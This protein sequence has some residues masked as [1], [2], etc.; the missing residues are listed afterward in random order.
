MIGGVVQG[1]LTK[2][3]LITFQCMSR[4]VPVVKISALRM[5]GI[6]K[7]GFSTI[8]KPKKIG[9]LIWKI[10]VGS[11][12]RLTFRNPGSLEFHMMRARAMVAPVPPTLTNV[13]KKPQAVT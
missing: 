1:T 8:G 2:G 10:W 6:M 12:M 11:E 7:M 9:S 5:Y 4:Y 13:V 3:L